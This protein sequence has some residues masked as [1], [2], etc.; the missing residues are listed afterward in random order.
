VADRKLAREDEHVRREVPVDPTEGTLQRAA[1]EEPGPAE[2][3]ISLED[4]IDLE[5]LVREVASSL[6]GRRR[7]ILALWGSGLKRPEIAARLG[8]GERAVKRD[9][10]AIMEGR[11]RSWRAGPGL[12]GRIGH[13]VTHGLA[14]GS[15]RRTAP[16]LSPQAG[17]SRTAARALPVPT[18]GL[19]GVPGPFSILPGERRL[20]RH[21]KAS[22]N[23]P[24]T[25]PIGAYRGYSRH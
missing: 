15:A 16:R 25:P 14:S 19:V 20:R 12:L 1:S 22:R 6:S 21:A 17:M 24:Q 10:L 9:L 23:R 5:L 11:G 13:R 7:E 2:E 4:D 3:L 8:I 18:R